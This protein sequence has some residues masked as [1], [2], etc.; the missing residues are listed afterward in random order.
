M[1]KTLTPSKRGLAK[2]SGPKPRD[3]NGPVI[4]LQLRIIPTAK[5]KLEQLAARGGRSQAL[6]LEQAIGELWE[7]AELLPVT[8][9]MQTL[10][11][12]ERQQQAALLETQTRFAAQLERQAQVRAERAT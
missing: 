1:S 6:V 5:R 3:P 4:P 8:S 7:R 10:L 12:K 9:D 2:G 11:E